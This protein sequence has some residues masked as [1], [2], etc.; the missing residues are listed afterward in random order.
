LLVGSARYAVRQRDPTGRWF[1]LGA[2]VSARG[3]Q[4]DSLLNAEVVGE[5]VAE[6]M[7]VATRRA[8]DGATDGATQMRFGG[9]FGLDLSLWA[10]SFARIVVGADATVLTPS[11]RVE[12]AN[13]VVEREPPA[14]I[15]ITAGLRFV[16]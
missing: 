8:E 14:R 5:L 2:G 3:G 4:R 10:A 16:P 1:S 12:L 7:Q 13:A 11:I 9:R 15:A 6:R